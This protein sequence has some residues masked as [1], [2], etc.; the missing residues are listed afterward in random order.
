M[1][2][3]EWLENFIR[4]VDTGASTLDFR[5]Y[6]RVK[7]Q[8]LP[9]YMAQLQSFRDELARL[10]T[11]ERDLELR[12]KRLASLEEA[13]RVRAE[14]RLAAIEATRAPEPEEVNDVETLDGDVG[15]CEDA[16]EEV[17]DGE[18]AAETE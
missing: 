5:R 10:K 15:E 12:E 17:G 2:R 1:E 4:C 3:K 6:C 11:D 7:A 8:H 16:G 13:R 14:Q 9:R 18:E